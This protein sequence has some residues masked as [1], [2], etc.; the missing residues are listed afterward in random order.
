M[1]LDGTLGSFPQTDPMSG[2][3]FSSLY[4]RLHYQFSNTALLGE[5]LTHSSNVSKTAKATYE[6][7]E[8]LGDRVL[9]LA[10]A[11][12]LFEAFPD[13]DEGSLAPRLTSLVRAETCAAVASDLQLGDDIILGESEIQTGGRSKPAILADVCEAIIGAIFL[14]GGYI[15]ARNFVFRH[16][17]SY[18]EKSPQ[19][20]R[21]A[22]TLLQEWAQAQSYALPSYEQIERSGPD[23]APHFVISVHVAKFPPA[24]GEG[25]S[26]RQAEQ[27]AAQA[28]LKRE[29]VWPKHEH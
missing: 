26:K 16:W 22:K 1:A 11:E 4:Q 27:E 21:D 6:R 15:P 2:I 14:D 20:V 29:G 18:L 3:A 12:A 7:L 19:H 23:H 24:Q 10:I 25:A 28:F 8:F 5:A 9:G 17:Q 13:A